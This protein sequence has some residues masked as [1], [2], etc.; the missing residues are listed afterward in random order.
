MSDSATARARRTAARR[1]R[2]PA[3][4]ARHGRLRRPAAWA[5]VLGW[6]GGALAVALVAGT[7]VGA[8]AFWRLTQNISDNAVV[9]GADSL[10][11]P[12]SVG[13]Y[14]GGFN[15]LIIGSDSDAEGIMN[16][17]RDTNLND[18]NMLLHV[19]QDQKSATLVSFPRDLFVPIPECAD[20]GPASR[21]KLNVALYYGGDA[22]GLDCVVQTVQNLTGL[23]IQFA[24][25]ISFNGVIEMSNAVGGVDVCLDGG[26]DDPYTGLFLGPGTHTLQGFEA[27]AF[28]RSRHGVG[29]GSDL[30][31]ISSQ[32]VYLSSLVRKLKSDGTLTDVGKLYA[33]ATAATQNISLSQN[34][35]RLDT[36]VSIALVLKNIPLENIVMVQY[37][38]TT[39]GGTGGVTALQGPA[40]ALMAA[41]Q[42]D[43][44]IRLDAD[45]LDGYGSTLDPNAPAPSSE[46]SPAGSGSPDPTATDDPGPAGVVVSG[47]RGQSADQYTCSQSFQF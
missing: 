19:A 38:G 22:G 37:P 16:D 7:S 44:P 34:F 32:Q 11:A 33:L 8:I 39:A 40:S 36:L 17:G 35:A 18:V 29:D 30:S 9:I 26:I 41:I 10:A 42:A 2:G 28:L 45:S 23:D 43:Q 47:V 12:P 13:E 15:I 14:E 24:G 31:R 25:E 27:L 1:P 3:V 21:E 46:P 6:I 20:Y 5:A 4:I